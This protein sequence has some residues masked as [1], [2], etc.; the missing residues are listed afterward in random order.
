M[1]P[2]AMHRYHDGVSNWVPDDDDHNTGDIDERIALRD[3]RIEELRQ[4]IDEQRDLIAR[5]REHAEDYVNS[6]EAWKET[7]GMTMTENGAWTWEPFWDEYKKLI[8]DYN[9]FVRQWN[10]YLPLINREP[11]NVGRPL[12]AS[13][14][15]VA[16]VRRLRGDGRSLRGIADDTSLGL[17]TVRT[18]VDQTNRRDRT[19][20]KHRKRLEQID[21][22][23][24]RARWKRQRR[25][26]DALPKRVQAVVKEGLALAKEARGLGRP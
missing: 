10:A 13:D 17:S 25:V 4:E 3:R 7:F 18:I 15:Q 26:G 19:T 9:A 8:D 5:L 24:Q 2:K 21:T 1:A 22:R 6:I 11:R 16:E 23:Q 20:V 12:S 14:A